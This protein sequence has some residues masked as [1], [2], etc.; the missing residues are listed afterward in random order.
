MIKATHLLIRPALRG[1][2]LALAV[3]AL[4]SFVA[5]AHPY[6]SGIS[7]NAGTISFILNETA[8]TVGV[9]FPENA[10]TNFLGANLTPGVY[11]FTLGPGTNQYAITVNKVGSG[12]VSKISVD[13]NRFLNFWGPRG[14]AVNRSP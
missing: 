8:D 7:N 1:L 5:Q 11:S 13:T 14:V 9:Y 4:S 10:S 12:S 3:T 2:V 6:A